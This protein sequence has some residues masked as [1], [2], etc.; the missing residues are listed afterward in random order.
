VE[1]KIISVP[2]GGLGGETLL[3]EQVV[4]SK[5][6]AQGKDRTDRRGYH[7]PWFRVRALSSTGRDIYPPA[8]TGTTRGFLGRCLC[9]EIDFNPDPTMHL[10]TSPNL[11][12]VYVVG[13]SS[14]GL[15]LL[16]VVIVL[17]VRR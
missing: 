7:R 11:A 17:L 14:L 1:G 6:E 10:L 4:A 13:G 2:P 16:I 3:D 15:I 5:A 8:G 12:S 9:P